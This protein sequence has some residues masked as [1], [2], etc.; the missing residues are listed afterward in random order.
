MT[1][2]AV[3]RGQ[4]TMDNGDD[5]SLSGPLDLSSECVMRWRKGA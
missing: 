2:D 4:N 3:V 1:V 5:P